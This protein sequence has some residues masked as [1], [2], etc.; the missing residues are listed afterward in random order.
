MAK[1][2]RVYDGSQWIDL[3]SSVTDLSNYANLTN[4][5]VSGFRN[6]IINGDFRINQ[7]SFSS[8][9]TNG[10]YGFDR[11]LL[12]YSGGTATYS[13][14]TFTAGNPITGYEPTNFARIATTSQSA[15]S[16]YTIFQQKIEDVRTFA[17]QTITISLWAKASTG[18]PKVAIEVEQYFGTT[19]SPSAAVQTYAGQITLSTSWTRYSVT[20]NIPSISGKT[21]TSNNFLALNL[22]TS[23]GS[24]FNTRSG[25]LGIQNATID[26]WGIQV[27]PGSVATPF[28]QRPIGTE[29]ALCQRYY[30][31]NET[32]VVNGSFAGGRAVA[33][34]NAR[35][36]MPFPVTMRTNPTAISN[37]TVSNNFYIGDGV[38]NTAVTSLTFGAAGTNIVSFDAAVASGLTQY[39][40][41]N[42]FGSN[43]GMFI[44][45][46]AEL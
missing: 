6:A 27:E 34:N 33:T 31:R 8:T 2:A 42:I 12:G 18:T 13:A 11:W 16:T 10:T 46:S 37:T 38:T 3:A 28:E 21:I 19:G 44:A 36:E 43:T 20:V 45:F 35:F 25:S 17:G 41:V 30:Y 15:T 9:T 24:D 22:W 5:P 7:R 4:T 1:K 40:P 29:L 32:S 14:Q 39:R 26:F 23:A